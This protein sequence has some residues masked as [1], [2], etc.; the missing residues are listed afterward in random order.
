MALMEGS[1]I[2]VKGVGK[3]YILL[4][5]GWGYISYKPGEERILLV[6]GYSEIAVVGFENGKYFVGRKTEKTK[7]KERMSIGQW[8]GT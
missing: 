2:E 3:L 8:H 7:Q 1:V 5:E 6:K 4:I